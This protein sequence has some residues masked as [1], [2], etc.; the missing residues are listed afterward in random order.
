MTYQDLLVVENRIRKNWYLLCFSIIRVH[1]PYPEHKFLCIVII[2]NTIQVITETCKTSI[3]I[4]QILHDIFIYTDKTDMMYIYIDIRNTMYI[5]WKKRVSE[6]VAFWSV[7]SQLKSV[8]IFSASLNY[9]MLYIVLNTPPKS[10]HT[11]TKKKPNQKYNE[12]FYFFI[13]SRHYYTNKYSNL[14]WFFQRFVPWWVSC[15]SNV[16]CQVQ[17]SKAMERFLIHQNRAFHNTQ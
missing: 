11:H 5:L 9:N 3:L 12:S 1:D 17:S 15:L 13:T 6:A 14:Q 8:L 7:S 10:T 4:S 2:E 16:S